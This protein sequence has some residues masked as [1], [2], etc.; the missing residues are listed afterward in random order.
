MA[1]RWSVLAF[2]LAACSLAQADELSVSSWTVTYGPSG[3]R[4]VAYEGKPLLGPLDVNLYQPDYKGAHFSLGG[5]EVKHEQTGEVH[6][7]IFTRD[8]P[9]KAKCVGTLEIEGNRLRWT[10][11][12]E[13]IAP[14]PLEVHVP[15]LAEAFQSDAGDVF[16]TIDGREQEV[17]RGHTWE[18]YYPTEEVRLRAL[19][20]DIVLRPVPAQGRWVF[21]DRRREQV[22]SARIIGLATSTGQGVTRV[23]PAI[24][25]V[26]EPL[27]PE[28]ARA[29]KLVLG[30]QRVTISDAPV[31]NAGFEGG[32]DGWSH[33][34]NALLDETNPAEGSACARLE[35][36]SA[37][38]QSVYITQQV[39][40]TPGARYEVS[41]KL[42]AED[43]K[44]A[45]GMRM[46]CVG[47]ALILEWADRDG[48][49]KYSGAYSAGTF[50]SSDWKTV[51]CE[52]LIAPGDAGYAIIFLALRATGTAWFDD[53]ELTEI[54]RHTVITSPLDAVALRD[55]R[56]LFAWLAEPMAEEYRIACRGPGGFEAATKE[57]TYRPPKPL[58]PG[59]YEWQVTAGTAEPSVTWRF[60]Q[61]APQDADTTG[62]DLTIAPQ[63]FTDAKGELPVGAEDLSGVDWPKVRLTLDGKETTAK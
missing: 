44:A 42:R 17:V 45:E 62:P 11:A 20:H 34:A 61:T 21:Q 59:E 7:L 33:G 51:T 60:T 1:L 14:G 18:P 10:A 37:A 48:K 39:P 24:D 8:V 38:E 3:V 29:R 57:T 6:R 47:A 30:Q 28:E 15:I 19:D 13:M 27:A 32:L 16:F 22:S 23:V 49:W 50:G 46:T 4:S 9:D 54:K 52:E 12:M 41:C 36:A 35:V 25:I 2:L 55:N 5:C 58:P 26:V 40:I 63:S 56:P 53:V 43:V 31:V